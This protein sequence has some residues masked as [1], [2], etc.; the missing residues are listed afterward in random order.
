[1]KIGQMVKIVIPDH[2]LS[3]GEHFDAGKIGILTDSRIERP[4]LSPY[5]H[6]RTWYEV[7]LEGQLQHFREDYLEVINEN[8]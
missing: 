6:R 5:S 2:G 4:Y 1:M 7:L 8:R 3:C